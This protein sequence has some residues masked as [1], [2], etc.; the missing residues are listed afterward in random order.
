MTDCQL[1]VAGQHYT[2]W[3]T[4]DITRSIEQVASTFELVCADRWALRGEP[5]PILPGQ[6]GTIQLMGETVVDGYID[7]SSCSYSRDDHTLAVTG[8]DATGDLVD[9]AALTDGQ[10]WAGRTL[11]QIAADLCKPYGIKVTVQGD[12]GAPFKRAVVNTGETVL[13]VLQRAAA[14]RGKLLISDSQGGLVIAAVGGQRIETA[15]ELGVNVL[16]GHVYRSHADRFRT[17]RVVGQS[18]ESGEEDSTRAQQV[19]ASATDPAIRATRLTVLDPSDDIDAASARQ[20]ALWTAAVRAA[21]GFRADY[22]VRGW[23]AGSRLWTPNT[24]VPVRDHWLGLDGDYLISAATYRLDDRGGQITEL[25][26]SLPDAYLP[27]P[28]GA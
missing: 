27:M 22:T 25:T 21:R 17:Y 12:A 4:I 23:R 2:G 24:L 9:C 5:T 19:R 26:L 16:R 13:D 6:I 20:L 11:A 1:T 3:K 10:A 15:I 18:A 7:E 14:L 28:E 8:R